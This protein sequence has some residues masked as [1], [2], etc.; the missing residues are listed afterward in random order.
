VRPKVY[1]D[2]AFVCDT[3]PLDRV[4]NMK[5]RRRRVTGEPVPQ[6]EPTGLNP[7]T[8]MIEEHAQATR[9][10]H[11]AHDEPSEDDEENEP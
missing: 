1:R 2:G 5:R 8:L 3:V 6:T 10:M 11:L 4:A 9:L 7:L